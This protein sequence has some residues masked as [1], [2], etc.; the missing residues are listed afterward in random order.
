M[1]HIWSKPNDENQIVEITFTYLVD[2]N[3]ANQN[4]FRSN[5]KVILKTDKTT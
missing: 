4:S 1:Y 5:I 2:D 3:K